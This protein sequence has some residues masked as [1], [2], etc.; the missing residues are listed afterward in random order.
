MGCYPPAHAVDGSHASSVGV[1]PGE[2]DFQAAAADAK[3]TLPP[4]LTHKRDD[5]KHM[6]LVHLLKSLG[7]D[8]VMQALGEA[9]EQAGATLH[10]T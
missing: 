8:E 2:A 1:A 9:A 10:E 4:K 6:V 7:Q 5:A 3:N